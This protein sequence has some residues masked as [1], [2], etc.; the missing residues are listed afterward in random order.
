MY[1]YICSKGGEFVFKICI[2]S[3]D[4]FGRINYALPSL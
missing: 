3:Q 4:G 2:S 1:F